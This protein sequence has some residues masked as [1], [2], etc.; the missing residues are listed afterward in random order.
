MYKIYIHT[1]LQGKLDLYITVV[2]RS[3][4]ILSL[5]SLG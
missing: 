5:S 1:E 3:P 4:H 2:V